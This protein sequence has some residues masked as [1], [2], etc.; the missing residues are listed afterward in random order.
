MI[1]TYLLHTGDWEQCVDPTPSSTPI[2]PA[3]HWISF[4]SASDADCRTRRG[5]RSFWA[6]V[7]QRFEQSSHPTASAA[8]WKTFPASASQAP[9]SRCASACG[10][11][12]YDECF[13]NWHWQCWANCWHCW[14]G[15]SSSL[16]CGCWRSPNYYWW[17]CYLHLTNSSCCCCCYCCWR[18]CS[19]KSSSLNCCWSNWTRS[20]SPRHF[21]VWHAS[22]FR[23]A[24]ATN[25][26][27]ASA[28][29][30]CCGSTSTTRIYILCLFD[31]WESII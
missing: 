13:A 30:C 28:R 8:R 20:S 1:F 15:S 3:Q 31:N 25:A 12:C 5:Q 6:Q 18:S 22:R 27:P 14:D 11:D 29:S 19:L 4:A 9:Q 17:C 26:A 23:L 7:S 24:P 16:N 2:D 10:H 21:C